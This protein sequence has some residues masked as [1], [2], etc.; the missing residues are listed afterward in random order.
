MHNPE[1]E[2]W[3]GWREASARVEVDQALRE[4][5]AELDATIA[6]KGPTCW[7]SGKCCKFIE[8]EHRLYVTG[9]EIA[10][11][12]GQVAG[13]EADAEQQESIGGIRL[14]QFAEHPGACPYQI[15]GLCSTHA[16]RP[17]G[18][19]IFFCQQGTEAWQQ[20]VYEDFLNRLQAM[21]KANRIEYRYMDWIAGLEEAGA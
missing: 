8:F 1:S 12:L 17:L 10:W 13:P 7:S 9:L 21:H 18:C 4:L 6:A 16:I 20:D 2:L 15:D 19:H 11:F 14:P 3:A 5:Y